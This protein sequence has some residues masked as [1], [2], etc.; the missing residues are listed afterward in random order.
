MEFLEK[1]LSSAKDVE[2]TAQ[3]NHADINTAVTIGSLETEGY[4]KNKGVHSQGAEIG[5]SNSA[6]AYL[7]PSMEFPFVSKVSIESQK[8]FLEVFEALR[9]GQLAKVDLQKMKAAQVCN[10]LFFI[11][12]KPPLTGTPRCIWLEKKRKIVYNFGQRDLERGKMCGAQHA[13]L[14]PA[15][16]I[17]VKIV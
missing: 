12:V 8:M 10:N 5:G 16:I 11:T 15:T 1:H 2:N 3:N 14:L 4:K 17:L 6:P 9:S 7:G 13:P